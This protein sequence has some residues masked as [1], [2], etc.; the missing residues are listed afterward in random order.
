MSCLWWSQ[1][2]SGLQDKREKVFSLV[3]AT[4]AHNVGL[5]GGTTIEWTLF[6]RLRRGFCKL[7]PLANASTS[8]FQSFAEENTSRRAVPKTLG[9]S[10]GRGAQLPSWI[11][12]LQQKTEP[13]RKQ[14]A[15][16]FMTSCSLACLPRLWITF[17][18]NAIKPFLGKPC[19]ASLH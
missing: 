5:T 19:C 1:A 7:T 15:C 10:A 16:V 6:F 4:N 9:W 14:Q 17:K 18:A 11:M 2:L 13:S 8:S 3:L 12:K